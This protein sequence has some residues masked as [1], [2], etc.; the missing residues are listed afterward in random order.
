MNPDGFDV[1]A[2][3]LENNCGRPATCAPIPAIG[4]WMPLPGAPA[5]TSR[6]ARAAVEARILAA[7]SDAPY[8]GVIV[9]LTIGEQRAISEAQWQVFNRTGITHLVSISGLHV[10][11]FAA[12]AGGFAFAIT[13]RF[14]WFTSRLPAR[15]LAAAIG[16][17]A[18]TCY[19]LLAGAQ[20]PA[21]RTLIMLAVAALG[22]WLARPGT[23]LMVWLWALV[24]VVAF[25][26]W[27]GLTPGFWLSFGAVGLLLYGGGGRIGDARPRERSARII[28]MLADAARAQTLVTVGLVPLT[29]AI[30]QQ[31]SLVAPLANALAIP[32]V[33]FGVVPLALSGIALPFDFIWHVAHAIFAALMLVLEFLARSPAAVWQQHAPLPWTIA[34]AVLGVVWLAAPA[35]V[36]GRWLGLVWLVPLF[37]VRPEAPAAGTFTMSVLDVGQGLAVVLRTHSRAL[38]YDTGPRYSDDADAG[39]RIVAPYLRGAGIRKLDGLIV[40]HQDSDHSGGALTLLR[41][42][43]VDWLASSLPVDHPILA[44]DESGK[45]G[46]ASTIPA[47]RCLAGQSWSWDGVQFTILHPDSRAYGQAARKTNDLSCTLRVDS[48]YGSALVTGDI[49][50]RSEQELLRR[51]A[52]AL[53]ADVLVVPHHGSRTSSTSAFIAAVAPEVAVFTPGYRNRFGHPRPDVVARYAEFGAALYRTDHDGALTFTFA[54]GESRAPRLEREHHRRY[55]RD[56]PLRDGSPLD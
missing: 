43:P 46:E 5:T 45:A 32:V 51:D 2:W 54:P 20:I 40:S 38:L 22:I 17:V 14:P 44:R 16:L 24:A 26:P 31:V 49:E 4:G 19:V 23:A 35:A 11:V 18:A 37:V 55:W 33:T 36:P 1:E 50:A 47:L 52:R 15:K 21:L 34:A 6:R 25:D 10:T 28:A 53:S 13:R 48:L 42:V 30:F 39:G 41:T 12:L 27:A 8:A 56:M 7:L 3:L 29:L 9:A